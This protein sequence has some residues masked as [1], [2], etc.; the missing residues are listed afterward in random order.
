MHLSFTIT[1]AALLAASSSMALPS[2]GEHH[3]SPSY[4]DHRSSYPDHR[5][6]YPDHGPSYLVRRASC[7]LPSFDP[8]AALLCPGGTFVGSSPPAGAADAA[9]ALVKRADKPEEKP[10]PVAANAAAAAAAATPPKA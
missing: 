1:L 6:S 9:G 7:P 3:S 10:K 4:P 2:Y 8:L 5:S